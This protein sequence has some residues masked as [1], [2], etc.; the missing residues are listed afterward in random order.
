[1]VN[2]EFGP[3]EN[4]GANHEGENHRDEECGINEE[5]RIPTLEIV[6]G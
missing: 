2:P 3:N 1:V 6:S 5:E 4:V